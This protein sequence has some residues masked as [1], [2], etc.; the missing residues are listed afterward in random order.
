MKISIIT[1][2]W[3]NKETIKDAIDSVLSQIYRD[4]EYIVVDSASTDGT[5]EI[6]QSYGDKITKFISEKDKGIYDGLNKG[7]QLATGDVVAF[8]HSDD[9]YGSSTIL[10]DVAKAFQ[11]DENLDGIYG[12]LVYTPKNDTSKVL[13]YWK[14]KDFDKSLLAKGWMPAHPT[15][16]LKREVYEKYGGFDLSFNIA[17]DYDFMLRVL[18]AGIK[19]KYIPEVL[20]KMRVGGESN[21]SLKNITLKSGEDLRALRK[22]GVGGLGSLF[23]KNVSKIGQFIRK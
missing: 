4:I 9:I 10:E 1:S 18:N 12:D 15:L 7:V 3:N 16:F 6:V 17:G 19:V 22:N 5:V 21:K 13:R 23:I 2:V 11:S 20:Y 8:L 14:S